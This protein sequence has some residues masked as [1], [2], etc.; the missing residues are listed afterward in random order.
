M[1]G[2]LD[3]RQLVR[4]A[5]VREDRDEAARAFAE[6]HG[7]HLVPLEISEF[8]KGEGSLTCLSLIW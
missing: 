1:V 4:I 7:V 3:D 2:Q 6:R 5:H 8:E